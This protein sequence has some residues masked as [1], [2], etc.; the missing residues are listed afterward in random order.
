MVVHVKGAYYPARAC[1]SEG[2][3]IGLYLAVI[4]VVIVV[5]VGTKIATL[6]DLAT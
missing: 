1:A 5:V 3:A 6:V 2:K 4:V